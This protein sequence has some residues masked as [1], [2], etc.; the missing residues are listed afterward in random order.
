[1]TQEKGNVLVAQQLMC[2]KTHNVPTHGPQLAMSLSLQLLLEGLISQSF[3]GMERCAGSTI[4]EEHLNMN[5][6]PVKKWTN[7]SVIQKEQGEYLYSPVEEPKVP[8]C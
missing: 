8:K 3:D 7:S 6:R 5:V 4:G 2:S 1:M